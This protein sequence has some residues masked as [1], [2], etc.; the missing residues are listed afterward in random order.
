MVQG[1][2]RVQRSIQV[3][4]QPPVCQSCFARGAG[5]EHPVT[6]PVTCRL[7]FMAGIR[8]DLHVLLE[9][10]VRG[11]FT[12]ARLH[13]SPPFGDSNWVGQWPVGVSSTPATS[14]F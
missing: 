13:D 12:L 11:D 3:D 2:L 7:P 4:P 8:R 6:L 1:N 9:A 14:I 10:V 5:M